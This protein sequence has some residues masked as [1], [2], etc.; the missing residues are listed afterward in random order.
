MLADPNRHCV[1][2]QF[3]PGGGGNVGDW[4]LKSGGG[5]PN[6]GST[7]PG[8]GGIS[9]GT[10]PAGTIMLLIGCTAG[11]GCGRTGT[12]DVLNAA[13]LFGNVPGLSV[14]VWFGWSAAV[15]CAAV[16]GG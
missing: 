12:E 11:L 8:D 5:T 16:G 15:S 4:S 9:F 3:G 14:G 7:A 10:P 2:R 13:G 6:R 1:K